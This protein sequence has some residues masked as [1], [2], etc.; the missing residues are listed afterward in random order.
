MKKMELER[1][2][3]NVEGK[4]EDDRSAMA[5]EL[6]DNWQ[7]PIHPGQISHAC[8]L[9]WPKSLRKKSLQDKS[10]PLVFKPGLK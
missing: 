4:E 6:G 7:L 1:K 9:H 8:G 10:L 5:H 3:W 2:E